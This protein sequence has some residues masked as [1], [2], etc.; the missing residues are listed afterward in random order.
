MEDARCFDGQTVCA[1]DL[2]GVRHDLQGHALQTLELLVHQAENQLRVRLDVAAPDR[3]GLDVRGS[4]VPASGVGKFVQ[5]NNEF[6]RANERISSPMHGIRVGIYS[7]KLAL[8][9]KD[10]SSPHRLT[11]IFTTERHLEHRDALPAFYPSNWLS[12]VF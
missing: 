2:M 3:P 4:C 10:L 11:T 5:L 7:C 12:G 8:H 6:A 9:P 1:C